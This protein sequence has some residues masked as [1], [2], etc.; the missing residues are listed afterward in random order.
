V[1][2][3]INT[4][5]LLRSREQFVHR[6]DD[7]TLH[8]VIGDVVPP[9]LLAA[10]ETDSES[11]M[12]ERERLWYVACTRARELLIVPELP[13]AE[14]KSLG[15]NPRSGTRRAADPGPLAYDASAD[16]CRSAQR[17]DRRTFR[18]RA[19]HH[20]RGRCP[21]YLDSAERLRSRRYS[22]IEAIALEPGDA[23]EVGAGRVRGLLLHKLMGSERRDG[24]A[25]TLR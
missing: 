22:A 7:D 1:V 17:A 20:R 18:R 15:A 11:L 14:Q 3:P 23:P 24:D 8:W 9:E 4:A 6:A 12:R 13:Q 5:T 25:A 2:I 16:L 10:L 21:A 19:R